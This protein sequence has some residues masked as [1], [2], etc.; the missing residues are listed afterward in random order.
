MYYVKLQIELDRVGFLFFSCF[1][2]I[3]IVLLKHIFYENIRYEL[4]DHVRTF[5]NITNCL[6]KIK[7]FSDSIVIYY[8]YLGEE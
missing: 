3:K 8:V 6:L 2:D 5:F 4:R 1:Y 7:L